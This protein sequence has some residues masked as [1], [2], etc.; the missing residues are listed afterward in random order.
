MRILAFSVLAEPSMHPLF[1]MF[2]LG[3]FVCCGMHYISVK[4]MLM[5]VCLYCFFLAIPR[6][7]NAKCV[8]Q[9]F[10]IILHRGTVH[11]TPNTGQ[12]ALSMSSATRPRR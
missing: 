10:F 4:L 3:H 7:N 8:M 5:Q 2:D 6:Y 12:T 1:T 11:N 9:Q